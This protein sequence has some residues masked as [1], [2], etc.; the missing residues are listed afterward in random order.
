MEQKHE[1]TAYLM[2]FNGR[3]PTPIWKRR[4]YSKVFGMDGTNLDGAKRC[5]QTTNLLC[6]VKRDH[7]LWDHISW[8]YT[9]VDTLRLYII[10][11]V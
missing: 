10:Y 4:V 8:T 11:N 9:R 7:K 6:R 1:K 2:E 5:Q 3:G